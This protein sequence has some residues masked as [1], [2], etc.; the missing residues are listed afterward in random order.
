MVGQLDPGVWVLSFNHHAKKGSKMVVMDLDQNLF[1][2]T[3]SFDIRANKF[4]ISKIYFYCHI[5]GVT[6]SALSLPIESTDSTI[7]TKQFCKTISNNMKKQRKADSATTE[8]E[9]HMQFLNKVSFRL[10]PPV[11]LPS[12]YSFHCC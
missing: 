8:Y 9:Y 5:L 4:I 11:S 2:S 3:A 10:D 12:T 7:I 6:V 1:P